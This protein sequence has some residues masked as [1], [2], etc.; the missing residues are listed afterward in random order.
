MSLVYSRFIK[1]FQ[2]LFCSSSKEVRHLARIVSRDARST[3]SGKIQ[4][5][6]QISGL[7]PWNFANWRNM[8]KVEIAAVPQNNEWRMTML[9]KLLF[10]CLHKLLSLKTQVTSSRW[11]IVQRYKS[12]LLICLRT[13]TSSRFIYLLKWEKHRFQYFK[14]DYL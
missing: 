2:N 12:S 1:F 10:I 5:V 6:Q 11:L 9:I 8:E 4:H 3:F 7:S 13:P 14:F